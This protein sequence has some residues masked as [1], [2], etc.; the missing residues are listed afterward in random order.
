MFCGLWVLTQT[1]IPLRHFLYPGSVHWNEEGHRFAWHMKLRDKQAA[2]RF[3]VVDPATEEQW[4]VHPELDLLEWQA[5]KMAGRPDMIL[6]YAHHVAEEMGEGRDLEV[7]AF[8]S[9]SLNGRE[10]QP[11]I[12]STVD[13]TEVS[14]GL[15]PFSWVLPLR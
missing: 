5:H 12:D 14:R 6:E 15:A 3:R 8:V 10:P 2:A 7:Y 4:L 11:L 9:A 1:L 13:L